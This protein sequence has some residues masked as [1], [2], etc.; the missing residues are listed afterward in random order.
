MSIIMNLGSQAEDT[1]EHTVTGWIDKAVLQNKN[2]QDQRGWF[3]V[4]M[5]LLLTVLTVRTIKKMRKE[6]RRSY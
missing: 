4:L 2:V 1:E 5:V 6:A 3:H